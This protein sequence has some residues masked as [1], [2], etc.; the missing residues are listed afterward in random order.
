M[1]L[2]CKHTLSLPKEVFD[3]VHRGVETSVFGVA[4]VTSAVTPLLV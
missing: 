2:F 3:V 4:N 1:R